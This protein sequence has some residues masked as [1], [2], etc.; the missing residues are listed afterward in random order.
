ADLLKSIKTTTAVDDHTVRFTTDGPDPLLLSRLAYALI[1]PQGQGEVAGF[2][3]KGLDG[4]GP[5]ELDHHTAGVE[6]VIKKRA[7]YW[8]GD[9]AGAPD[10]MTYKVI[11]DDAARLAAV[12]ANEL[13]IDPEISPDQAG[14]VPQAKP[15]SV[16][17]SALVRTNT[18]TGPF[19]D[20]NLR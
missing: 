8:G 6:V 2:P 9:L 18:L 11:P 20:Q 1:V 10:R 15:V 19:A 5:Y 17:E 12:Q 14:Q 4:S 3:E 16:T 13:D 7:N